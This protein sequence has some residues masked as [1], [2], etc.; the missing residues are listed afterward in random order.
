MLACVAS[1]GIGHSQ[2]ECYRLA[3]TLKGNV[4]DD[5]T[6]VFRS[7]KDADPAASSAGAQ[8][9]LR[10]LPAVRPQSE[11]LLPQLLIGTV[12]I[13]AYLR[14]LCPIYATLAE[15]NSEDALG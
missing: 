13:Y 3:A 1:D 7:G 6:T 15:V 10:G 14:Y 12:P 2:V 4:H 5:T 11:P 8:T 9:H